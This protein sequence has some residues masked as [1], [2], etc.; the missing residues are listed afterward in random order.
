MWR[1]PMDDLIRAKTPD[2]VFR[3]VPWASDRQGPTRALADA[4]L[5]AA[6][7]ASRSGQSSAETWWV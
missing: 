2:A 5:G 3:C 7:A 6:P 1:D 4:A